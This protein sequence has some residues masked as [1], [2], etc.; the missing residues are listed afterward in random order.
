MVVLRI[1]LFLQVNKS[2]PYFHCSFTNKDPL[3]VYF[4][5]VIFKALKYKLAGGLVTKSQSYKNSLLNHKDFDIQD[6]KNI[7]NKNIKNP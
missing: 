5:Q 3:K 4:L 6:R 1:F 7:F 2:F